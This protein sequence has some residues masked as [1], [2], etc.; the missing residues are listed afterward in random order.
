MSTGTDLAADLVELVRDAFATALET[1]VGPDDDFFGQGGDSLN[2]IVVVSELETALGVG[3]SQTAVFSYPTPAGLAAAITSGEV[4]EGAL[5]GVP[6]AAAPAEAAES[7]GAAAGTA[8]LTPPQHVQLT[9]APEAASRGFI[10]WVFQLNGALDEDALVGAY[11]DVVERFEVLR[12]ELVD[13]GGELRQRALPF[14]PG[15]LR[16]VDLREQP[17][18]E[19]IETATAAAHAEFGSLDPVTRPG[20]R[21]TLYRVGHKSNVLTTFVAEALVDADSA[22]MLAAE[23]ARAYCAR[24]GDQPDADLPVVSPES[25]LRAAAERAVS[26]AAVERATAHWLALSESAGPDRGWPLPDRGEVASYRL[27]LDPETEWPAVPA[28]AAALRTTQY[29]VVLAAFQAALARAYGATRLA[30]TSVVADRGEPGTER[31]IGSF[32]TVVR[33]PVELVPGEAFS[34]VTARTADG[35]RDAVAHSAVPAL[36]VDPVPH[37]AGVHFYMLD[38]REGPSFPGIRRRRFRLHSRTREALRLN[39][40]FGTRNERVLAFSAT[41]LSAEQL[42]ALAHDVRE[43]LLSATAD[44]GRPVGTPDGD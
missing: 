15:V 14:E 4:V 1:E 21:A 24:T 13:T 43:I 25:F 3:L 29:V 38:G 39:C 18:G 6:E 44:P 42:E 28:A 2:A 17:K 11:D 10:S 22:G 35:V 9:L 8:P 12:T 30:V 32:H 41:T 33:V 36:L 20:L 26:P 31:M 27:L 16:V 34:A 19:A 40:V 37:G 5:A 23:L 7:A